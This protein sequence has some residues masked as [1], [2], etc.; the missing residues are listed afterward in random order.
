MHQ[1]PSRLD[2]LGRL[3]LPCPQAAHLS[4]ASTWQRWNLSPVLQAGNRD[5]EKLIPLFSQEPKGCLSQIQ[6]Q[7]LSL[8]SSPSWHLP[9]RTPIQDCD[10]AT[11]KLKP[12]KESI[13]SF[14]VVLT[15]PASWCFSCV[16]TKLKISS[17][18]GD[19]SPHSLPSSKEGE[20]GDQEI[21]NRLIFIKI[22]ELN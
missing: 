4:S 8:T 21:P 7:T 9:Q 2:A 19:L 14:F 1:L 10:N 20:Q 5:P 13:I 12:S 11:V 22:H 16:A 18:T 6:W 17:S 3:Y 15:L